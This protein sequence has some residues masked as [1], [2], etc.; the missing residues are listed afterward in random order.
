MI[1]KRGYR[2]SDKQRTINI[3]ETVPSKRG[4]V[5][6][7]LVAVSGII[8]SALVTAFADGS[9]AGDKFVT[10]LMWFLTGT[11][12]VFLLKDF[13]LRIKARLQELDQ[14]DDKIEDEMDGDT[15]LDRV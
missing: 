4:L 12:T 5:G 15:Y 2:V 1:T 6:T 9:G 13:G 10:S 8:V 11:S 3:V 14:D 7:S